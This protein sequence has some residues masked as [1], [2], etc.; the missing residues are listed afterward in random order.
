MLFIAKVELGP[1]E[2]GTETKGGTAEKVQTDPCKVNW[3][4]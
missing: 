1:K 3:T 2:K 4:A